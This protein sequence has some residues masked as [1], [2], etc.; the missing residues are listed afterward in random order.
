MVYLSV[1]VAV[2]AG[3]DDNKFSSVLLWI[4]RREQHAVLAFIVISAMDRSD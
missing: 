1:P 2:L 4:I 3:L